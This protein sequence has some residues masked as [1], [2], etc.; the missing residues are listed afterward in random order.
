MN[1]ENNQMEIWL[2]NDHSEWGTAIKKSL[3]QATPFLISS[4][5]DNQ[6]ISVTAPSKAQVRSSSPAE[7]VG[8]NPI[9]GMNVCLVNVVCCQLEV[10]ATN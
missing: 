8:S 9:R 5:K 4:T 6:Q 1:Q 10:S 2:C 3:P 7:I